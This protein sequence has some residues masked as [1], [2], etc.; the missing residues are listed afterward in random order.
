M[1]FRHT[2][3]TT[4]ISQLRRLIHQ[5]NRQHKSMITELFIVQCLHIKALVSN[6]IFVR[7]LKKASA[8]RAVI[9]VIYATQVV[10]QDLSLI[11]I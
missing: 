9:S 7:N 11:H 8:P 10:R 5:H 3:L 4:A 6:A 2:A 1:F